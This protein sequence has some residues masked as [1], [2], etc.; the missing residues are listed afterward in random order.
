MIYLLINGCISWMMIFYHD[1]MD[2]HFYDLLQWHI[3]YSQ[4]KFKW[5]AGS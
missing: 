2:K 5:S 4:V 3:D 1:I